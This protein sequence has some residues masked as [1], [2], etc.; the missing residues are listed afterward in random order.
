VRVK[1][2]LGEMEIPKD[3][4]VIFN[5]GIPGFEDLRKFAIVSNGSDPIMWL[6]SLEDEKIALPVV[7]PW[8]IRIDYT[9]DIPRDVIEDLEI[10]DDKDVQIWAIL[11][12]PRDKPEDMTIN[13][14]AP[15]VINLKNRRGK[16]II[17]E[18]SEYDIRHFVKEE[19]ERSR[20]LAQE[21]SANVG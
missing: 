3:K 13:L 7:D 18:S 15:I 6:V 17:M 5:E 11:V 16:Q 9:V 12:I 1:T 19:L 8:L 14:L 20:K 21:A 4:I 2:K 10:E